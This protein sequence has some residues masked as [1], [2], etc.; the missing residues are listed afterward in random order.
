MIVLYDGN[1]TLIR[2]NAVTELYHNGIRTSGI[3]GMLA[4]LLYDITTLQNKNSIEK[5]I[6]LWDGGSKY[7][8]SIYPEYKA[9]RVAKKEKEI[10]EGSNYYDE[11]KYQLE[12]MH[13]F[14][15]NIGIHSLRIIGWEADDLIAS[16]TEMV[17]EPCVIVTT[18]KDLLQLVDH[19]VSVYQPTKK[20]L[21]THDNFTSL[22]GIQPKQFIDYK[23]MVGDPSDNIPGIRGIGDKTAIKLLNQYGSIPNMIRNKQELMKSKITSKIFI[24]E[25]LGLLEFNR[26]LVDL[27]FPDKTEILPDIQSCISEELVAN[28]KELTKFAGKYGLSRVI[29]NSKEWKRMLYNIQDTKKPE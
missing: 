15:P 24:P 20:V 21:Y 7:R 11:L 1:N 6:V 12:E 19:R 5:V 8:K 22:L 18:D 3:S 25:N 16:I 2:N 14:L 9:H 10:E 27:S 13:K 23:R 28:I 29:M 17:E 26:T 4:Q